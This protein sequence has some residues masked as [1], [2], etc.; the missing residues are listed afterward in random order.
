M[1]ISYDLCEL[2]LN[3]HLINHSLKGLLA[4]KGNK[5]SN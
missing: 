2:Y 1:L 5:K 4:F 3:G